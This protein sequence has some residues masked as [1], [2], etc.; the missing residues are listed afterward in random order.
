MI[1]IETKNG[2]VKMDSDE[3]ARWLC[4]AEAFHYINQR[5]DELSVNWEDMIK[6][7]AIEKYISERFPAMKHD[8][9][10][11]FAGDF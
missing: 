10:I 9:M 3:F 11:E 1:E 5:A 4:F 2:T 7:M 8:V 6:P